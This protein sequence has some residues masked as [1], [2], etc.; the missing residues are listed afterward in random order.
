M[1]VFA[2]LNPGTVG[3]GLSYEEFVALAKRHGFAAVEFG[4][5]WLAEKASKEGMDAA[6][7]WLDAQGIR[8]A[9]FWL[10]VRW[11]EDEA[12]F[13]ESLRTL[14]QKS[15]NGSSHRL[16]CLRHLHPAVSIWR[17]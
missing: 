14:P 17:P 11:R 7:N 4:I 15:P 10:P 16:P 8:H 6:R 13:E 1:S 3:G 5:D 12:A 9:A 2:C